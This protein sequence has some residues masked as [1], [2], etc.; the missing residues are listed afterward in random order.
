MLVKQTNRL[1][2]CVLAGFV[3]AGAWGIAGERA[4][5]WAGVPPQGEFVGANKCAECHT[6]K[7]DHFK[8]TPHYALVTDKH[9]KPSDRG[10]EACHGP[11]AKHAES[12]DPADIFN[13]RLATAEAVSA[14]CT[15]ETAVSRGAR[16]PRCRL[17]RLSLASSGENVSEPV[18]TRYSRPV[19]FLPSR[20]GLR[21]PKTVSP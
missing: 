4:V 18:N 15:G 11:G 19:H 3:L 20:S 12:A 1:K 6:E 8:A 21:I 17:Q 7:F 10:C 9:T 14:R 2:L 5:A 13:P 16:L